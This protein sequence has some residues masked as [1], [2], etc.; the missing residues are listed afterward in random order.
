MAAM[1]ENWELLKMVN[2]ERKRDGVEEKKWREG[3]VT[4]ECNLVC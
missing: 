2:E 3:K 4:K 1:Q